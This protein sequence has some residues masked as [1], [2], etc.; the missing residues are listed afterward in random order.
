M[1]NKKKK[2]FTLI[3]LVVVLVILGI[4]SIMSVTMYRGYVGRAMATEGRTLLSTIA[5]AEKIYYAEYGEFVGS[6][7][8]G[9]DPMLDVDATMNT[10]FR[11][12]QITLTN[13]NMGFF[14]QTDGATASSAGISVTFDQ[15]PNAA[16]TVQ[17][18]GL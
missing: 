10:Y 17:V 14:A 8:T 1:V 2:G 6:G 5:S 13:G 4:V 9:H 12:Y 7:L 18:T 11:Q 16:P 15:D 3:E